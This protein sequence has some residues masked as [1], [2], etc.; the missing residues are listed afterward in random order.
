M[1][2]NQMLEMSYALIR[3]GSSCARLKECEA[4]V[5]ANLRLDKSS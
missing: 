5:N 2:V 1:G 4:K 3:K